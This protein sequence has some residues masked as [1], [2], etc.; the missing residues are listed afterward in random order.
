M[1]SS[2][3][4]FDVKDFTWPELVSVLSS[5]FIDSKGNEF[6]FFDDS[7]LESHRP[8]VYLYAILQKYEC[9]SMVLEKEYLSFSFLEDF[10]NYYVDCFNPISKNCKRLHFFSK[11]ID[12]S[13]LE[14]LDDILL[15][16]NNYNDIGYLGY[17]VLK[18]TPNAII[19]PTLLPYKNTHNSDLIPVILCCREYVVNLF[20]KSIRVE[21]LITQEQDKL[22]SVCATVSIFTALHIL[23]S[24]FR[25]PTPSTSTISEIVGISHSKSNRV[26]RNKTGLTPKS[27]AHIFSYYG[28][29]TITESL[30]SMN[31]SIEKTH[32]FIQFLYAYAKSKLPVILSLDL[33]NGQKKSFHS[34]VIV[35][36]LNNIVETRKSVGLNLVSD[37]I[38]SII[39]HDEG[40]GPNFEL[41][42]I[43]QKSG[44]L[45]G[46]FLKKDN[47]LNKKNYQLS[48]SIIPIPKYLKV[49]HTDIIEIITPI[50][51]II[52]TLFNESYSKNKELIWDVYLNQ[53]IDFKKKQLALKKQCELNVDE[54]H[55]KSYPR[56]VWVA[57]CFIERK[58]F[59]SFIFDSTI[60]NYSDPIL[61][62]IFYNKAIFLDLLNIFESI[63]DT[64]TKQDQNIFKNMI[65]FD[66]TH[67]SHPS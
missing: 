51:R 31:Y 21:T 10:K 43:E 40:T 64:F 41:K 28:F 66:L 37:L 56:Y 47:N 2:V 8:V 59:L 23:S 39:V 65:R 60:P 58:P 7:K 33:S 13:S 14:Q 63:Q 57:D 12:V 29:D 35:G 5:H 45:E 15:S 16:D 22:T 26:Y 48:T 6:S 52:R 42:I 17:A 34:V 54:S 53:N 1:Q 67:S 9:R 50:N 46:S 38:D 30:N 44:F 24:K 19:G 4:C 11:R 49:N 27:M 61:E 32:G 36:F 62:R 20:G 55:H 18:P 25:I 3:K